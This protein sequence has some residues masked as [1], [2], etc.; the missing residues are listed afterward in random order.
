MNSVRV[1]IAT[2]ALS[3]ATQ[4]FA[5]PQ[6]F[7]PPRLLKAELATLPVTTTVGGGEV[8]IEAIVDRTGVLGRP[9]ILRGT[10]PYTQLVFDAIRTWRFTPARTIGPDGVE[11]TIEMPVSIG[12]AYRAPMLLNGPTIAEPAKDWSKPSVDV[13]YPLAT[14]MPNYPADVREGGVV[15]LEVSVNEGGIVTET[16]SVASSGGFENVSRDALAGWRFRGASHRA[17]PVPSTAYVLF[18]FREPVMP[19]MLR[20]APSKPPYPPDYTPKPPAKP[21]FDPDYAPDY[22]P[23]PPAKPP[24]EPDYTPKPPPPAT[25]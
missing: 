11:T 25:P 2:L 12:A 10:P 18:G 1:A 9:V 21:P 23:K 7:L 24:F 3:V 20:P 4:A 6:Q 13:A 16:R 15:L 17:R 5:Q 19:V 8:L 22:T 14:A